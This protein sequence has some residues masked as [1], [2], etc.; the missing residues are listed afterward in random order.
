M[1]THDLELHKVS[2]N[3]TW[4]QE[5]KLGIV[6]KQKALEPKTSKKTNSPR[7]E[8]KVFSIDNSSNRDIEEDR[9]KAYNF[10][11]EI[12]VLDY[13][14]PLN[15][16][17]QQESY[18]LTIEYLVY[19]E[20]IFLNPNIVLHCIYNKSFYDMIFGLQ[21]HYFCRSLN[22]SLLIHVFYL[23]LFLDNGQIYTH[24]LN[25]LCSRTR[26]CSF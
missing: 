1:C 4:D 22:K 12:L 26:C 14:F 3:G 21:F 18:Y 15:N 23:V 6:K 13:I 2:D 19:S 9:K 10:E 11:K 5:P 8:K 7:A 25:P 17:C 24:F 16:T 20:L